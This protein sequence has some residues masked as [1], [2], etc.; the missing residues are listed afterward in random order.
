VTYLIKVFVIRFD[1]IEIPD[2]VRSQI[3][4]IYQ[5]LHR[6]LSTVKDYPTRI[7]INVRP[8]YILILHTHHFHPIHKV[9]NYIFF[10]TTRS[11]RMSIDFSWFILTL[12]VLYN[13]YPFPIQQEN[14]LI[15]YI[16]RSQIE[17]IYNVIQQKTIFYRTIISQRR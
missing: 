12:D 9:S 13:I 15:N 4:K 16:N 2:Q 6:I 1:D 5:N 11:L 17:S 3:K 10:R 7:F 14:L 8:I